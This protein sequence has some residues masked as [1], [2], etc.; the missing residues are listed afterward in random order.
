MKPNTTKK[1]EYVW[2]E[3]PCADCDGTFQPVNDVSTVF[4]DADGGRIVVHTKVYG[5]A[6]NATDQ[7][8]ECREEWLH[9]VAVDAELANRLPDDDDGDGPSLE[10]E[11]RWDADDDRARGGTGGPE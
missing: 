4:I 2:R 7:C 11:A 5:Y 8:P 3:V 10:D 1:D 9:S 6:D